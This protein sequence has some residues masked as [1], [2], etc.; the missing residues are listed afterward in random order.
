MTAIRLA[1]LTAALI[2]CADPDVILS[3]PEPVVEPI[4]SVVT[5]IDAVD[6]TVN[7]EEE[8]VSLGTYKLTA[9][10]PCEKCCGKGAKGITASG[11]V[12]TAGRTIGVNPAVIPYGTEVLID[13]H[14]YVAEDTGGGI[15]QQH[16]DVFYNTHQEAL[17]QGVIKREVFVKC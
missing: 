4:A 9:Y 15:K 1:I 12:A 16:I 6:T 7:T 8:W 5:T 3:P 14:V 17:N 11:T 2:G 10:C 13:G